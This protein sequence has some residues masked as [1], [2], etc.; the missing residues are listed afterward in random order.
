MF[1]SEDQMLNIFSLKEAFKY[2]GLLRSGRH[3]LNSEKA[4]YTFSSDDSRQILLLKQSSKSVIRSETKLFLHGIKR[5]QVNEH[6]FLEC[7]TS[8]SSSSFFFFFFCR[9]S[10]FQE[11]LWLYVDPD[12]SNSNFLPP[13]RGMVFKVGVMYFGMT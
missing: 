12:R 4:E 11:I 9:Y 5:D 3:S 13:V 7:K 1:R 2:Y 6:R 10:P 8:A